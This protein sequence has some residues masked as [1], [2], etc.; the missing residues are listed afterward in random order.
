MP[1]SCV[2]LR[3]LGPLRR[4]WRCAARPSPPSASWRSTRN[5]FTAPTPSSGPTPSPAKD[6]SSLSTQSRAWRTTR[7]GTTALICRQVVVTTN[8]YFFSNPADSICK[9]LV[10][11]KRNSCRRKRLKTETWS[12]GRRC[13]LA[14][15]GIARGAS[16]T[17]RKCWNTRGP[18]TEWDC[19]GASAG[20]RSRTREG[21]GI[22]CFS[23]FHITFFKTMVV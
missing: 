19:V 21:N 8:Y 18:P 11:F 22:Q 14:R 20:R 9:N 12:K 15:S 13:T 5:R 3:Q 4:W 23:F 7:G 2:Q 6:A 16:G 17:P 10:H 1:K